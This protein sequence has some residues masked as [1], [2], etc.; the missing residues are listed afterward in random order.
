MTQFEAYLFLFTDSFFSNL[1]IT[2]KLELAVHTMK[3][4]GGYDLGWVFIIALLGSSAATPL[5]YLAGIVGYN[6]YRL[7]PDKQIQSKYQ[8]ITIFFEKYGKYILLFAATPNIGKFT[9]LV[10]GFTRFG[11][12][13]TILYTTISRSIYYVYMLYL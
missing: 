4:L 8:K 6:L 1:V 5:N 12:M 3:L 10:A 9:I 11:L 7:S 2:A 13:R